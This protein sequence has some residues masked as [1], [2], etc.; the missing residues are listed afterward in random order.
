MFEVQGSRFEV[1]NSSLKVRGTRAACAQPGVALIHL[2][3]FVEAG[4]GF[5]MH[6]FVLHPP[7]N[8]QS[9]IAGSW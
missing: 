6:D 1:Q 5:G 4:L 7:E 8:R 2:L 9:T 3:G